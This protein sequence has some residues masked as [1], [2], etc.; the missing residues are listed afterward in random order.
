MKA[1]YL[2]AGLIAVLIAGWFAS[3]N[4]EELGLTEK[5]G[6]QQASATPPEKKQ[7]LFTVEVR[8]FSAK[9]RQT[10]L[11]VRGRT[12]VDKQVSVLARTTGI[13][14][15]ADFEEGDVVSAGNLLCRLDLRDRKARLAQAKARL[16][17][18]QRDY[19]AARKLL[20][21]NFASA[22]K[23]ASDRANFDA[24]LAAVE[25]I[26]LEISYTNIT[27]PISGII[28]KFQGEKGQFLQAGKP[29]AIISVFDPLLVVIQVGERDIDAIRLGQTASARLVTGAKVTGKVSKIS[30]TADV[31]TRT[32]KVELS[33]ANPGYKL[34][35]GITAEVSLPLAPVK[36]HLVPAGIIGLDDNGQIGVRTI[37]DGNKVKF[38]AVKL[39]GQTRKGTWVQGLPD[40]VVII[41]NGQDYVLSGQSVKT[42]FANEPAT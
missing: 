35:D 25:Q 28:T 13:I 12:Q 22:A 1:S 24:A 21:Q 20:K 15:Q 31:A 42:V 10:S 40:K 39:V 26:E 38:V 8:N 34:R 19:E 33:V 4:L 36:A 3:G 11:I 32:F 6:R 23:V 29:C 16:V 14:E 37:V 17:S 2:W 9:T 41:I 27:A 18:R 7:P 5:P 30:P